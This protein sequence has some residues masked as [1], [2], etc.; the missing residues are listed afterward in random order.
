VPCTTFVCQLLGLIL[1]GRNVDLSND[2]CPMQLPGWRF[3]CSTNCPLTNL[4]QKNG[5]CADTLGDAAWPLIGV[6]ILRSNGVLRAVFTLI[7][8]CDLV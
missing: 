8:L 4:W 5:V 3:P 7:G 6:T 1:C 2:W